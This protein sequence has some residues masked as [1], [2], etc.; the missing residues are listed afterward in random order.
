VYPPKA[1]TCPLGWLFAI[2]YNDVSANLMVEIKQVEPQQVEEQLVV[3]VVYFK[4]ENWSAFCFRYDLTLNYHSL[5]I[6]D[7]FK[8]FATAEVALF[9]VSYC[10]L[11]A[12]FTSVCPKSTVAR[13]GVPLNSFFSGKF[14]KQVLFDSLCYLFL[15][16]LLKPFLICLRLHAH[17]FTQ[18]PE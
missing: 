1:I 3:C 4:H 5:Q 2:D 7:E 8:E 14:V 13:S 10:Q 15:H 11:L 6:P 12:L 18:W 16:R 9:F 17:T